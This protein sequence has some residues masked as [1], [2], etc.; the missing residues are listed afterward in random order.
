MTAPPSTSTA[1][2]CGFLIDLISTICLV[3][4]LS[5]AFKLYANLALASCTFK[6][7]YFAISS[8]S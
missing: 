4:N 7:T 5:T 3:S 1:T 8:A 2:V 6:S